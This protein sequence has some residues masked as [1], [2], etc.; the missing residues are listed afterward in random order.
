[1]SEI[2]V[3][4]EAALAL[5][6]SPLVLK[7]LGPT[8]DYIGTGVQA[9]TEAGLKNL[10]RI[11]ESAEEKLPPDPGPGAVPP[12]VLARVLSEGAYC[13]DP[14]AT[15]YLGGVLASS[16]SEVGRD[17]RGAAWTALVT[18]L[19]SYQLRTHYVLYE[20]ARRALVGKSINLGSQQ[21][22]EKRALVHIPLVEFLNGLGPSS[23]EE[24]MLGDICSHA[25]WGLNEEGL[26]LRW[27]FGAEKEAVARLAPHSEG[28]GV[29][30]AASVRGVELFLWGQGHGQM[31]TDGFFDPAIEFASLD[32]IAV[33]AHPVA[34]EDMAPAD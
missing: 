27:G 18:R 3:S 4:T 14:V 13:D 7:V 20:S 24:R 19:S 6:S 17:D 26:I 16:R 32:D 11:F 34:V 25:F 33:P 8:A 12:R 5:A 9:W 28:G 23:A 22:A 21:E 2:Q 30:F 1:M 15:E 29:V 10:R 31:S